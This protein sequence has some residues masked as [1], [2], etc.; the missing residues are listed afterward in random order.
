M[1]AKTAKPFAKIAKVTPTQK[2]DQDE[3]LKNVQ[4][5]LH[6]FGYL[7]KGSYEPGELDDQTSEALAKYQ[8]ANGRRATGEFNKAT[9]DQMTTHRC[10]L[11]DMSSGIA[12]ATTCAWN[13]AELT[14]AFDTGTGDIAGNAEF[15][16]VRDAFQTWEQVVPLTFR[17]VGINANPDVRIGWR[18]A[19]DPD[20]SMVGGVLA[21]ADFPPGCS[22]VTNTLPKPVHFDDSE[23]EWVLG[24]VPAGFDVETV[25]LHE[26]GHI[27]GL[28]HSSVNGAVMFASV[29]ANTTKRVLTA[30][31]IS[32]IQGLYPGI[33]RRGDSDGL[34][35]RVWEIAATKH[36]T[37]QVVTAVRTGSNTLQLISWQVNNDGSVSRTGDSGNQAGR[38]TNIDI[39]RGNKYVTACRTSSRRLKLI[40]WDITSAGAISRAGDSGNQAGIASRIKLI[41]LSD[42][43]FLTACRTAQGD[44]KLISWR[45]N[46]DGSITRL[47]DSGSAAG[48]V[49]DI[50]LVEIPRSGSGSR[51]AT[52]VRASNGNLLLIVW[53]VSATGAIS[54]RGDSGTQAG[55]A[56][57]IRSVKDEFDHVVTSVRASNGDLLL[58]SWGV[59]ANGN[60]VTR[61]GDSGG[62]AG[63]IGDN[64]LMSRPG[65]VLSAV[66]TSSRDLQLIAWATTPAGGITRSGDSAGPAGTASR[67]ALCQEALS[68]NAPIVPAL[69]DSAGD[70]KLITWKD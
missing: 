25:A 54:R 28:A 31:D 52:S 57:M 14:Y 26:I 61:L 38:A 55:R 47:G 6:R 67:I 20:Y 4:Q 35:G 63:R 30:D 34:A 39:A 51:V 21:H 65:G 3:D 43:L 60:T 64:A 10:G 13:Q 56:T 42:T 24:A 9:R 48:A 59:S 2:G 50:S 19:N 44:L 37:Q 62:Q 23:H 46:G 68:G 58:I 29:S 40:S 8:R 5:F 66:R 1:T 18:P 41:A 15:Q 7:K 69:R 45:L 32:G 49:S 27:L 36:R 22:V 53:D 70:L 16:A 11:P 12:F 33:S 17:E